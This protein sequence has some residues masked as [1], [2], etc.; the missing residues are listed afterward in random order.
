MN[1]FN[2]LFIVDRAARL[3]MYGSALLVSIGIGIIL[4]LSGTS[5]EQSAIATSALVFTILVVWTLIYCFGMPQRI[6]RV[7][8]ISV[9]RR[10]VLAGSF[11]TITLIL[12]FSAGRMEAAVVSKRLR[13][14]I[15]RRPIQQSDLEAIGAVLDMAR[16]NKVRVDPSTIN[17][18]GVKLS[19]IASSQASPGVIHST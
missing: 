6:P 3:G 9:Q 13:K 4:L 11:F 14:Y 5:L 10:A 1:R 17:F 12:G 18:V 15:E 8:D 2:D 7:V 19:Q 16:S